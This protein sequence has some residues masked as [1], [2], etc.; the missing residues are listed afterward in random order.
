MALAENLASIRHRIA[1]ACDRA[2]RDPAAVTLLAVSKGMPPEVVGEAA[3]AGL[4]LFGENKV[5]EAKAK[6]PLCPGRLRWHMIGHLQSNKCRDAV[7]LFEMLHSVDSVPLAQEIQKWADREAKTMPVLLEVNLAGES[8][9]FGFHPD[10]VL[11]ALLQINSLPRVE[12]QGLMTLGPW[13]PDPEKVRPIFRQLRDL[14]T[15]C[16]QALGAPL[17][18][19]SMGMSGDFEVAVEEGATILRLGTALFGPRP[20]PARPTLPGDGE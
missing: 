20:K 16:D 14:K 9:K 11:P 2:G 3:G 8:A 6:I 10:A 7:Q 12:V 1:A 4:T 17:P 5:Q 13:T 19:L 18:H 15:R